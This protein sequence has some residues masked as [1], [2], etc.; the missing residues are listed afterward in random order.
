M[1]NGVV[2]VVVLQEFEDVLQVERR[3]QVALIRRGRVGHEASEFVVAGVR[4][5][6]ASAAQRRR[7]RITPDER[8]AVRLRARHR[9]RHVGIGAGGDE[10]REA[11]DRE[12][13]FHLEPSRGGCRLIAPAANGN[14]QRSE[15]PTLTGSG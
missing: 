6:A 12:Q 2:L 3:E 4:E 1:T 8:R 13:S 14:D 7:R 15:L 10:R 9:S 5:S 11:D